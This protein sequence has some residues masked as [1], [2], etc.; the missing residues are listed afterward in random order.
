MVGYDLNNP[1][2]DYAKLIEAIKSCGSWWHHLDSTWL[3]Q[4]SQS[5][6]QVR[7]Y[8]RPMQDPNDEL[9][10]MNVTKDASAWAGFNAEGSQWLKNAL[11]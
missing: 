3:V 7:D 10:V 4:T 11:S 2:K 1:G 5:A 9:L 6:T 8:L